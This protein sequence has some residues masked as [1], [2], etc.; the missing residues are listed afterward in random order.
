MV[1]TVGKVVRQTKTRVFGGDTHVEGK[2][3][4]VFETATESGQIAWMHAILFT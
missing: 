1:E 4:S 3:L 2:I